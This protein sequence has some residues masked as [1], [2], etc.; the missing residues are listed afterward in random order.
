MGPLFLKLQ[1]QT[2]LLR[3]KRPQMPSCHLIQ[4]YKSVNEAEN[5][6]DSPLLARLN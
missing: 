6:Q 4:T 2:T 3:L 5:K 1:N